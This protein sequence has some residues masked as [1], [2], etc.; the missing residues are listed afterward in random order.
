MSIR[1]H[2]LLA[3]IAIGAAALS[4]VGTGAAFA[5]GNAHRHAGNGAR[6]VRHTERSVDR[7]GKET[8][9]DVRTDPTRDAPSTAP[10]TAP[11][12]DT[13]KDPL[14]TDHRAHTAS[15]DAVVGVDG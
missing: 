10:S 4:L 3:P 12:G 13:S 8:T 9:T 11:R 2:R 7:S 14:G 5:A 15:N 1:R 6:L